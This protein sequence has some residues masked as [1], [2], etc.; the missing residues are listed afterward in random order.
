MHAP[1][2]F[3]FVLLFDEGQQL[4]F[5]LFQCQVLLFFDNTLQFIERID[6]D[7][8]PAPPEGF[9]HVPKAMGVSIEISFYEHDV[10]VGEFGIALHINRQVNFV[11]FGTDEKNV[12]VEVGELNVGNHIKDDCRLTHA[13]VADNH[14]VDSLGQSLVAA[15]QLV[16]NYPGH[17][18]DK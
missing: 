3:C 10:Q 14:V 15:K 4:A 7:D 18:V 1:V 6:G 5:R 12:N 9:F 8:V 11:H 13:G 2:V 16:K 17:V